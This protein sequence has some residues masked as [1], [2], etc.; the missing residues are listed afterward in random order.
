MVARC[1]DGRLTTATTDHLA[2]VN[3]EV[4][5]LR[6]TKPYIRRLTYYSPASRSKLAG[7]GDERSNLLR[8]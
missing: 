4:N 1:G 6:P 3:N 8:P 7:H 5:L 2:V